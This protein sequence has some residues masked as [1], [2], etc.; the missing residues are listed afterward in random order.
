MNWLRRIIGYGTSSKCK[1][2]VADPRFDDWETV[3][4]FEDLASAQSWCQH[5][6]ES[7]IEAVL[8]S[9]WPLDRYDRGDIMLCVAPGHWSD[10]E[11]L[12]S[13]LE[14]Y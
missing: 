3:R 9:D 13:G 8:T 1:L 11:E 4:Q 7:G 14:E 2:F 6:R 10:A 12:L 5:L